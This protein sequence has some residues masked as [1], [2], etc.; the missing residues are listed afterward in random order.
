VRTL[1]AKFRPRRSPRGAGEG[2]GLVDLLVKVKVA[3]SKGAARKLIEGGG[4]Y[5][6]N[7]R[8]TLAQRTVTLEDVK[9]PGAILLRSGKKSYQLALVR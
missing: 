3:E 5:L 2:I 7:E 1:A 9:M 8:Q 4:A 6:N